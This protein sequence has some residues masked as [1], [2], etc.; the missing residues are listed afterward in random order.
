MRWNADP[1]RRDGGGWR[2]NVKT[3]EAQTRWQQSPGGRIKHNALHRR[4]IARLRQE[5]KS[6]KN[7]TRPRPK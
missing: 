2:C 6:A 4:R 1:R 3:I 7:G 5:R